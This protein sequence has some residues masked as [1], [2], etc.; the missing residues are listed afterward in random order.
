MNYT[1]PELVMAKEKGW[2]GHN[3]LEYLLQVGRGREKREK[4]GMRE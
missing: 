2:K 3:M 1:Y 4:R